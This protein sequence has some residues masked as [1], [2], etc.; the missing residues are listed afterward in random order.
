MKGRAGGFWYQTVIRPNVDLAIEVATALYKSGA[1]L[2]ILDAE[3][4]LKILREEDNVRLT[5]Y[6]FH[7]YMNHHEEGT[8]YCLPWEYE[9]GDDKEAP[10]TLAQYHDIVSL[11]EWQ[12][13]GKV[14]VIG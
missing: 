1:P 7:D 6:V 10:L 4:L 12:E 11:A 8:V 13:I 14:K 9:C 2:E 3:K 5:P